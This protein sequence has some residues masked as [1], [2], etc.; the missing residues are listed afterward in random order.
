[1]FLNLYS[2]VLRGRAR[3]MMAILCLLFAPFAKGQTNVSGNQSGTW[4]LAGSPYILTATVTVPAGQTLTIQPGVVVQFRRFNYNLTVN[5]SLQAIGTA[6]DSIRFVGKSDLTYSSASNYG[7]TIYLNSN[8]STLSYVRIDSLGDVN[9]NG[10]DGAVD[11]R[12]TARP[13]IN[14][15]LITNTESP[16]PIYTW[17]GGAER[18]FLDNAVIGVRAESLARNC[19][20]VKTG[21]NSYYRLLG[22]LSVN[23]GVTMTIQ[24]GTVVHFPRFNH[25]LTINGALQAVGTAADSIRFV[26]KADPTYSA[27]SNYGGT[28]YLNSNA[29]TLSFVRID[30]LGD[31]N[32]NGDAGAINIRDT[33]TPVIN[34]S[35]ITHTESTFAINTWAGGAAQVFLNNAVIGVRSDNLLRN[36]TLVKTGTNSRYQLTGP[37]TVSAGVTMTIQPGTVVTF[38]RYSYNLTINGSL[39]AVGTPTDSIR[40][41]GKADPAY[42]AAS[43]YGGAVY[44]NSSAST[45]SYIRM[46]SL[47]DINYNGN[48]GSIYIRDTAKPVIS[49]SLI[50]NTESNYKLTTWAGGAENIHLLNTIIGLRASTI[51]ANSTLPRPATGSSYQLL[52]NISINATKTL[53]IEPGCR[54][55]FSDYSDRV[56]VYGTLIANGTVTDSIWFTGGRNDSRTHGGNIYIVSGS[57]GSSIRYSSFDSLASTATSNDAVIWAE[58]PVAISNSSIRNYQGY[59]IRIE[60]SNVSVTNCNLSAY[61]S[62][63]QA[64]SLRYDTISPVV[65]SCTFTGSILARTIVASPGTI[66]G[67]FNNTNAII[68][69][70]GSVPQHA[71]WQKPGINS[72]YKVGN[73][74]VQE[75]KTLTIQP[76]CR[77]TLPEYSSY[78]NIFGTLIAEGTATDSI[79]FFGGRNSNYAYGGSIR[80]WENSTASSIR[81]VSFDSLAYPWNSSYDAVIS[82]GGPVA[83]SNSSFRNY[84]GYAVDIERSNV[85]LNNCTFSALNAGR[86][87]IYLRT[88][89]IAPTITGC[90]FA[91]NTDA[92]TLHASPGSISG[93][94]NNTNAIIDLSGAVAQH[95]TWPKPGPGSFYRASNVVVNAQKTLTIQPGCHIQLPN[96]HTQLYVYGTL[97]ANGTAADS[98]RFFGGYNNNGYSHGGGISLESGSTGSSIQYAS[99]DSLAYSYFNNSAAVKASAPLVLSH[100]TIRNFFAYA[101][102]L[103]HND[104]SVT[105][106]SIGAINNNYRAINFTT[107][108]IAPIIQRCSFYGNSNARSIYPYMKNLPNIHSNYNAIINLQNTYLTANTTLVNPGENSNYALPSTLTVPASISLT[109]EPG[110]IIDF[111]YPY[112]NINVN[113]TLRALGSESA[114]I[115]FTALNGISNGGGIYL[116]DNS[117]AVISNT[118]LTRMGNN[119]YALYLGNNVN[120]QLVNSTISNSPGNGMYIYSGSPIIT[121]CTVINNSTGIV[122]NSG[123]PVFTNCNILGNTQ[124]GITNYG[125]GIVDARN[126]WWGSLTGPLHP[127]TNPGGTGNAVSDKVLFDPW[128]NKPAGN[129]IN[130]IGITA[131]PTP[132]TNCG[133]SATTPVKVRI[134]N[135]G[136]TPQTGFNVHYRINNGPVITEN[137][138]SLVITPASTTDYAFSTTANLA[139]TGQYTIRAYT[140]LE[141]DSF[142]LNDTTEAVIQH[143]A[144]LTPPGNLLPGIN[145]QQL[146]K[147][148]TFS[149]GPVTNAA[150]YELYVWPVAES[151]PTTPSVQGI[152]QINYTLNSDLLQFGNTYKWKVVAV[153]D[154][155]RTESAVQQ[156]T[157]RNLPD[158]V[159]TSVT[160][161]PVAVSETDIS[162]SWRTQNQGSGSTRT[163][164]WY[165]YAYLSDAPKLGIG[166]DYFIGSYKNFSALEPGQAY[167]APALTYRIPQGLQGQYYLIIKTGISSY[168]YF[169]LTDTNNLRTSAA[170]AITLAPPP[171]LQVTAL[172]VSP[173]TAFSED[174]LTVSYTITNKGTGPTNVNNWYD[175]V[176][177]SANPLFNPVEATTL[178]SAQHNG[179]LQVEEGYNSIVKIKI[180]QNLQGTYYVHVQTDRYAYV[181]EYD[182]EDNNISSSPELTILL[183]PHPDLIVD[184]ISVPYDSVSAGQSIILQWTTANDGSMDVTRPWTETL[185]LST[186][187]TLQTWLDQPLLTYS[188]NN[189]LLS[190]SVAGVQSPVVIPAN[191]A[192]GNYYF[193]CQTDAGNSIN[194]F[195]FDNNNTSR[196]AGPVF[197][198]VPDLVMTAPQAPAG[199]SSEQS[200]T[201]GYTVQNNG[202]G[203]LTGRSW[204]DKVYLSGNTI[205]DGN[206]TEVG[207]VTNNS[208]QPRN[209]SYNK[210]FNITLPAGISG[211]YYLLFVTDAGGSIVESNNNN[212][213]AYAPI[214][215]TLS[216]WADLE[217]T[218]VT[219]PPQDTAGRTMQVSYTVTNT[220]TGAIQ[221]KQWTER[222][223][224]SPSNSLNDAGNILLTTVAQNRSLT[225]GQSYAVQSTVMMPLGQSAGQYYVVVETDATGQ[226]FENTG[227]SNNRS[228]SSAIQVAPLP[229]V[230]LAVNEGSVQSAALLAGQ[231]VSLT[232]TTKN[233][234]TTN[235]L[236]TEW[237]DAVYLSNNTVIDGADR[238]LGQWKVNNVMLP[239]GA[240]AYQRTVTI[241]NT[242]SGSFYLIVLT[243]RDNQQNDINRG[244]NFLVLNTNISGQPNAPIVI[245]QPT[246]S[247]L[248]PLSLL[249]PAA[250]F[251]GEAIWVKFTVKNNGPGNT[252]TPYWNDQVFVTDEPSAGSIYSY[253]NKTQTGP[254]AANGSYTDSLEI[255]LHPSFS[256][257]YYV[258][259]RTDANNSQYEQQGEDNNTATAGIFIR[260][261]LP[262]DLV[263]NQVIVPAGSQLAGQPTTIQWQLGNS[264]QNPAYGYLK[265]AVYLSADTVF[266]DHDILLGTKEENISLLA[267]LTLNRTLTAPLNNIALG[268]YYIIVRTD[269]L[270]SLVEVQEDNN[271]RVSA[272]QLTT[273]VKALPLAVSTADL[274]LNGQ[275]LYYRLHIPASLH[276]ETMEITLSGDTSKHA[277]NRIY[278][279]RGAVP[280]PNNYDYAAETPFE[281][282]Q[283]LIVPAADSGTYYLLFLGN[284]TTLLRRQSVNME[285]RIIPFQ[286]TAV[287]AGKG[288]NT[289]GVTLKIAGANFEPSTQFVLRKAGLPSIYPYTRYYIDASHVFVSYNLQGTSLGVYDV[290]AIKQNGDSTKLLQGFEIVRGPGSPLGGSGGGNGSGGP[291]G[292][293]GFVCQVVNIGYE[294][295]ISTDFIHAENT[296]LNRVEPITIAYENTS[297]IDIPLP[298]RFFISLTGA[299]IAFTVPELDEIKTTLPLSFT[300]PGAPPGILRA[301]A[302]GFIKLFT[303]A[304]TRGVA[305][306]T[307]AIIE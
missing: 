5:G 63:R 73:V 291:G 190:L 155:C 82:A 301:G 187:T 6:A 235:T 207:T 23:A 89:T 210:Q 42:T 198:G 295:L 107:D 126:C 185:Y 145:A 168:G 47:G 140:S 99:F 226:V 30:S 49:Q 181:F 57:A 125:G 196:A 56:Y 55:A 130:D 258:V 149:W 306:L 109:I 111:I 118:L 117:H 292:G 32:N 129:Q 113:G 166:N 178:Y 169:E 144:A 147:P 241:P 19:T 70:N 131:I 299:P 224:L 33:A 269:I 271:T 50:T 192:E 91:G 203:N 233:A 221:G 275:A 15:T 197:V 272:T 17:A 278:L 150:S 8:A 253:G 1:M 266:D 60:R 93:I 297:S 257:N 121:G 142:H 220:G 10:P 80:L 160:V 43:N 51:T 24:P 72:L 45:L 9:N 153:R 87:S 96:Y 179:A 225:N 85:A 188:Q 273:D 102:S 97:I 31:V 236:L 37:L 219:A 270:N 104:I 214:A 167:D 39:Q 157:L 242:V 22:T 69:L 227:E 141:T 213:L 4:T 174:T 18:V 263:I 103:G 298:T 260:P 228:I 296:R 2:V 7:G 41:I 152:V 112:A 194:E 119:G 205:F 294:D 304:T 3:T 116:Y 183:R 83:I 288:G 176:Y 13:V 27:A 143:L 14:H 238:L 303:K 12:D 127:T 177:L 247:D 230:D 283:Q 246:P 137:V 234:G 279:K 286:I 62:Q 307:F 184:N 20:L 81:Y 259:L 95:A 64:I 243:D 122:V 195:P 254:L 161:P 88:D 115:Q 255:I 222:V 128:K 274:L 239:N 199:A 154:S 78:F 244:N 135:N 86:E 165:E 16:Y 105:D 123:S 281:T 158:L 68:E 223:Y 204:T 34:N 77:I 249:A 211:N 171:D 180:P 75:G 163:A 61:G 300:E 54:I 248:Q 201:V 172:A 212:N 186:D 67:F 11:I 164:T 35:L 209:S 206:D 251:A 106:C 287:D 52:G 124:A 217:V 191:L 76:G 40:F 256:G 156:F 245:T 218:N 175:Q 173:A 46:D 146:D 189:P 202:K 94:S 44:L 148:V 302:K 59:G 280:A 282:N 208:V 66:S 108:T 84:F 92:R 98:I 58:G 262:C 90:S 162:F 267:G 289:G 101:V 277:V 65:Q 200:I 237:T 159:V 139:A 28:V 74:T 232:Y 215:V 21:T 136:N 138:G 229:N 268:N 100:S 284:D 261:Q 133:L 285:A 26:G 293:T 264:G 240:I 25:N 290:V 71:Q 265:E 252:N 110:V 231:S 48:T 134:R 170:I 114:P 132:F 36:A 182:K 216:P 193:I 250:A 38:P 120:I 29:S 276:G 79:R 305:E 151:A 53:T